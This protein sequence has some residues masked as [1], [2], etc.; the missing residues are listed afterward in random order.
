MDDTENANTRAERFLREAADNQQVWGLTDGDG[1][2]V[3]GDDDITTVVL[4][5]QRPEAEAALPRFPGYATAAIEFVTL[6]EAILPALAR[7]G[8]W[9]GA[10]LTPELAGLDLDPEELRAALQDSRS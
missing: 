5:S 3:C 1:W 7:H 10:N 6:V 2:A 9:V 8:V 4:W